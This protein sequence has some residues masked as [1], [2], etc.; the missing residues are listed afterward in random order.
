MHRENAERM[1]LA[2]YVAGLIGVPGR[3]VRYASPVSVEEAIRIAVSVQEAERK[4]F[5][6]FYV[7]QDSRT[8]SDSD[9]SR[10]AVG[11]RMASQAEG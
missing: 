6:N 9:N 11:P 3:Q 7:R 8:Y 4:K 5:N 10:H 2:S 1:L